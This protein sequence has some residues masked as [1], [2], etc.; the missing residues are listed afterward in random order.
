[1]AGGGLTVRRKE[2]WQQTSGGF[3][4]GFVRTL[5]SSVIHFQAANES[6]MAKGNEEEGRGRRE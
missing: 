6:A 1:M 5:K 4:H 3:G 2:K